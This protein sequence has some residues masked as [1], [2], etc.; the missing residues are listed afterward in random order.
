MSVSII[1]M[2]L[3]GKIIRGDGKNYTTERKFNSGQCA[4]IAEVFG[5]EVL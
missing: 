4:P 1:S 2:K 5:L 3:T